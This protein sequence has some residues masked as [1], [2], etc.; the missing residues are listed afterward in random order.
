MR[1]NRGSFEALAL[2]AVFP[3]VGSCS[4]AGRTTR[5]LILICTDKWRTISV[6]DFF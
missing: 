4:P 2:L 6:Y 5:A 3:L 1:V